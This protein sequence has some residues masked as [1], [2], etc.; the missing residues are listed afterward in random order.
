MDKLRDKI[1][2]KI[3]EGD[4]TMHSR[5]YYALKAAALL[6]IA[7]A[8]LVVSVFICNF[9]FFTL[10]FNG[11]ESLLMRPGGLLLFLR[12]FP[13]ELLLLDVAL[14]ALFDWLLRQF[15][16]GYKRPMVYLVIGT[17]LVVFAGGYAID[18]A[19]DAN[20]ALLER[21]DDNDL[22]W[23]F[24]ELYEHARRPLPLQYQPESELEINEDEGM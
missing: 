4:V 19:T 20:D 8:V 6:V 12:F 21:A 18:R 9:I 16:F 15:R 11:H 3:H 13:W 22:F 23:P 2:Q 7:A 1:L 24:G 10:R 14:I 17:L 5:A